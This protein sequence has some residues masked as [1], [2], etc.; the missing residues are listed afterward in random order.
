MG[1]GYL[2]TKLKTKTYQ[3]NT[4]RSTTKGITLLASFNKRKTY[5][6]HGFT[7]TADHIGTTYLNTSD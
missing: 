1:P 2:Q 7:H 4:R 5:G 3:G 6:D